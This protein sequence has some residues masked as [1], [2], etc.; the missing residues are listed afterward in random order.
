M[1]AGAAGGPGSPG[2]LAVTASGGEGRVLVLHDLRRRQDVPR[3]ERRGAGKVQAPV[4]GDP[5]GRRKDS[6]YGGEKY[7]CSGMAGLLFKQNGHTLSQH[8]YQE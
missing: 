3:E 6:S 5:G 7:C 1:P 8:Q 4:Q 2:A